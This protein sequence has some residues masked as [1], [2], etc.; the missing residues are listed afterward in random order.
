M[1]KALL[2]TV[3]TA[4][5]GLA[6]GALSPN[7]SFFYTPTYSDVTKVGSGTGWLAFDAKKEMRFIPK[8][9]EEIRIPYSAI[10]DLEYA[11]ATQPPVERAHKSK[12]S[13]PVKMNFIGKHQVTIHYA[14][15]SGDETATL[16]LEGSN[17]QNVLG[18]L[19]AKTGLQ[20]KRTGQGWE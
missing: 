15:P 2:L 17:Y 10:K 1:M 3:A 13:L 14:A 19:H 12:F 6:Q 9:G 5:L 11:K 7:A 20:V 4:T 8:K 18:T 16:W